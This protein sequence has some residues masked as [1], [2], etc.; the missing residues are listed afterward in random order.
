M[1]WCW[2]GFT[3]LEVFRD[4]SPAQEIIEENKTLSIILRQTFPGL[5]KKQL[6]LVVEPFRGQSG[7]LECCICFKEEREGWVVITV[8]LPPLKGID[9]FVHWCYL[10][11]SEGGKYY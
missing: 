5:A 4:N 2:A 9:S 11:D 7:R 8:H 10:S 1:R 6:V 3:E